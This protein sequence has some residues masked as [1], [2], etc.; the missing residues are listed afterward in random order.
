MDLMQMGIWGRP[1]IVEFGEQREEVW[2]QTVGDR[3]EA[4]ER[5]H[6]A[7]QRT[8]LEFRAG[9]ERAE[10]MQQALMLA[11]ME[12]V[13]ELALAGERPNLEARLRREMPDPVRPRQ[14]RGA[15]ETAAAFA[16]RRAEHE[17][18]CEGL[19]A[20]RAAR[21]TE[22]LEARREELRALPREELAQFALPRRIDVECWH[23][24]TRTA[25]DWVLLRAVRK[26]DEH[27]RPYFDDIAQVQQLHPAVKEQLRRAYRELEPPEGDELPKS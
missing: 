5:G 15:G 22:R 10:A 14:D 12:E 6:E 21:L 11:P 18:A 7:M 1:C 26:V 8:L 24:F 27:E 4:L 19:R 16:Q 2:L 23:V 13:L 3:T 25:D 17:Q 20:T 9:S